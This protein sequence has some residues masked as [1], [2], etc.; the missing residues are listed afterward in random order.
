MYIYVNVYVYICL[1]KWDKKQAQNNKLLVLHVG[2]QW[3][4][5][6]SRG[7]TAPSDWSDSNITGIC[8]TSIFLQQHET[9]PG[10]HT[11]SKALSGTCTQMHTRIYT[12][13]LLL[14]VTLI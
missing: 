14:N 9:D 3:Q 1:N 6:D 10:A 4:H 12:E 8:R 13:L 2:S 7:H 11:Q 5:M